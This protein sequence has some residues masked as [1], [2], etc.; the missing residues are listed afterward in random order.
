[1]LW[2]RENMNGYLRHRALTLHSI[3]RYAIAN[4]QPIYNLMRIAPKCLG[5]PYEL[6]KKLRYRSGF[7]VRFD[8]THCGEV[9]KSRKIRKE[10]EYEKER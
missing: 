3:T 8:I 10:R 2:F 6:E 5:L 1:M 7:A 9:S 4:T